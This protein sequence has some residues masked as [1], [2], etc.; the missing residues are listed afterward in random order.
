MNKNYCP[1]ANSR[2]LIQKTFSTKTKK[3]IISEAKKYIKY[4][5]D[6]LNCQNDIRSYEAAKE[7]GWKDLVQ[8]ME[9]KWKNKLD[10]GAVKD[11]N[12][13]LGMELYLICLYGTCPY[14]NEDTCF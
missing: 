4:L 13:V 1:C 9:N 3:D 7:L 6:V 5:E 14:F 2:S 8:K 12:F 10:S 11:G